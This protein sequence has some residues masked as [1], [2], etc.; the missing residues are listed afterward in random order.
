MHKLV[1]LY[2]QPKDP[3]HFRRYYVETH[4]P[5]AARLPGLKASRY[6][7]AVEG[8]GEPSPWFCIFEGEFATEAAMTAALQSEIGRQVAA[9]TANYATGG[10]TILHYPA[11]SAGPGR[12][13]VPATRDEAFEAGLEVRRDMFG[14]AGA[15][16]QIAAATGFTRPMQDLVTRYCFGEIWQRP[17][18]D[19]KTRSMMTLAMLVAL[20]RPNELRIHVRGAI[21]NGA[22]VE[23]IR[24]VLLHAMIY[25]GVPAAVDSFRNAAEVLREMGLEQA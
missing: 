13:D 7:F 15:E 25:A 12:P 9:D 10:L 6:S 17:Q 5:L 3:E 23:E 19:R 18:I 8:L 16:D 2:G 11:E 21:A 14:A 20:A 22:T 24:E 4:L 1:V